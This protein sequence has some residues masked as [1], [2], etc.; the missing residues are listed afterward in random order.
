MDVFWLRTVVWV[1]IG[2]LLI[3]ALALIAHWLARGD[4][5]RAL[6]LM[7]G[8]VVATPIALYVALLAGFGD[9]PL[10]EVG[11][12]DCPDVA[13][14]A[15]GV[16]WFITPVMSWQSTIDSEHIS[17]DL[18]FEPQ[19]VE[20]RE[21]LLGGL[22]LLGAESVGAALPTGRTRTRPIGPGEISVDLFWFEQSTRIRIRVV[23]KRQ[24]QLGSDLMPFIE[25]FGTVDE[26]LPIVDSG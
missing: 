13:D 21:R 1:A 23:E 5:K 19:S 14:A 4:R 3:S 25:L 2:L 10:G 18:F 16:A 24:D 17:V 7:L 6:W 20:A 11:L 15:S 9:P 8:T 22:E 26:P 12:C